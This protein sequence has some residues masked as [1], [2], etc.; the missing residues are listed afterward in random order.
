MVIADRSTQ[1]GQEV[2]QEIEAAGGEAA[3]V[4]LNIA[5]EASVQ[6]VIDFT[7]QKYG[8]IDTAVNCAGIGGP[9]V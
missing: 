9:S 6:N 5:D 7:V 2:V 3:F 1:L 8:R 4:T